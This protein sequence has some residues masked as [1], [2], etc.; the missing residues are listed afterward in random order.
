MRRS[1]PAIDPPTDEPDGPSGVGGADAGRSAGGGGLGDG[2]GGDEPPARTRPDWIESFTL[3]A[4]LALV[5]V[6]LAVCALPVVTLGAGAATASVALDH[7]FEHRR[8]P[9]FGELLTQFRRSFLPGVGATVIAICV[10]VALALDIVGLA[11]G[12]VPG[13]RPALAMVALLTAGVI[14][15]AA[16]TVVEVGRLGGR[17]WYQALL[18]AGRT[19]YRRPVLP[20][21]IAGTLVPPVVIVSMI[22]VLLLVM[23]GFTLFAIH[24]VDRRLR[25]P[26]VA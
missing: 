11:S 21:A 10:A 8:W 22:P 18:A 5:G 23:P 4:D 17:G 19:A 6:G 16:L 12:A 15:M 9:V 25:R 7:W 24:V 26:E 2:A 3:G 20:L 1:R 14:A 13:G